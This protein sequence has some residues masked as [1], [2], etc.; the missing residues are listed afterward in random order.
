MPTFF[1]MYHGGI[2]PRFSRR[3]VRAF[4][5]R[6]YGLASSYVR[7]DIGATEPGRWHCWQLRWRIGAMSLEKVTCADVCA[8]TGIRADPTTI[9]ASRQANP[10]VHRRKSRLTVIAEL[11]D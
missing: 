6:A 4:I 8:P 9:A 2:A 1:S 10:K 3:A 11:L 5:A 7:R